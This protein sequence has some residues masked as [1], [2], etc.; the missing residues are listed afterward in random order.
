MSENKKYSVLIIDDERANIIALTSILDMEYEVFAVI[1]SREAMETAIDDMPDVILL[2]ILMPEM[3]GYEVIAA[4]KKSEKTKHIPIIFITGLDSVEAEEKG[5][6]LGAADYISKPFHSKI[7]R[8]RVQNQIKIIERVRIEH[9]LNVVLKLKAELIAAKELAE[10]SNRAKS[11][12][13][14][15]MSHEM[16]TPLNAI[17]G[18]AQILQMRNIQDNIKKN[19]KD[20][21]TASRTLLNLINDVL[22]VAGIEYGIL[23]LKES[24]FNFN[25]MLQ[26]ISQATQ[27]NAS[28]K[29]HTLKFTADPAIPD[30]LIGDEK[31]LRQVI[32]TLLANAVKFTPE[33]GTISFSAHLLNEEGD[34]ITLRFEVADNGIGISKEQQ[35]VIFNI[36]E[37]AEGGNTRQHGGIGVGLALSKR[38]VEIMGGDIWVES[39]P[40]KGAKFS[41]TC[42]LK[43]SQ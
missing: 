40:K 22:D 38:I 32:A 41:F 35:L 16:L 21:D 6:A 28:I 26:V 19:I 42:K 25:E 43:K 1:D 33:H 13:L 2:D 10:Y 11:E 17:M 15:R 18:I 5:L 12:F 37:Q 3:D 27:Y 23:K 9:D 29:K 20:L 36:F 4:L 31:R 34:E 39:E 7:A 8:L 30:S 24:V 14:S